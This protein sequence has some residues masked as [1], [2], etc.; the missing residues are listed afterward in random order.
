VV[1][2]QQ[3]HNLFRLGTLGKGGK[4]AQ[5][6]EHHDDLTAMAFEDAFIALRDDQIGKLG[7]QETP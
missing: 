2:T 3:C 1:F 5:I 7:R 4:A 6:A